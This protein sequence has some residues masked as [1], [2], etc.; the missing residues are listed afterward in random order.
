[1]VDQQLYQGSTIGELIIIALRKFRERVAFKDAG[2][3]LSY[4]ELE[5]MIGSAAARLEA[6][7]VRKGDAVVQVADNAT[8]LFVIMAACF[9]QG[10]RSIT[11]QATSSISDQIYAVGDTEAAVLIVDDEHIRNGIEIRNAV[12]SKFQVWSHQ[13]G[14]GEIGPFW[15]GHVEP[16]L[17]L[18]TDV[19]PEDIV[20]QGYTGGTT[21]VPKGVMI[22]SR[23]LVCSSMHYMA[24][25]PWE[26]DI[27]YLVAS[28]MAHGT[29]TI[30]LPVFLKGG[31][32]V[33]QKRFDPGE[34]IRA[35]EQE[36]ITSMMMVPTMLYA[37][38][39]HP[40]I[41]SANLKS[42]CRILYGA[43]PISPT[44]LREALGVFGPVF[45]QSYG[46]SEAPATVLML[47]QEDHL[48]DDD[49]RLESAGT[50]YPGVSVKLLDD[51]CRPVHQGEIGEICVRGPLVMSGYWKMPE[52]TEE[53]LRGGWLHTGDLAYQDEQGY[54]FI[55]DRKKDMI[56]SGGFNVYPNEVE[57]T[58]TQ[59]PAVA[60][61]AVIGIPDKKWGEAVKAFIILRSGQNASPDELIAFTK[62][63]KGPVKT[64]KSVELVKALPLT[65]V[66]K[67]DKKALR[68]P[69]WKGTSRK[70]NG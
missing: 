20:R 51:D 27:K 68:A 10:Y 9:I 44:R 41:S 65:N 1:M 30:I 70:V 55:V 57:N 53:T 49:K 33:L 32:T 66:G 36:G 2:R 29:S 25:Q 39:D 26:K 21:G 31:C 47:S 42:M 56:I 37:L 5:V 19:K 54:Y 50:P 69:Y 6:L 12:G 48:T 28:T 59:H 15:A 13:A 18:T 40:K 7:G 34:V 67:V 52:L 24:T 22:S 45:I 17:P 61:A 8:E 4:A 62:N 46:Q 3:T 11:L 16:K 63:L 14:N 58:L 43:A 23:S 35:I 60:S 38:L 64:P